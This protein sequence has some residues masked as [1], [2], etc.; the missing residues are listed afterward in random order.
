MRFQFSV[1]FGVLFVVMTHDALALWHGGGYPPPPAPPQHHPPSSPPPGPHQP[2]PGPPV[3]TPGG[4]SIPTPGP[5]GPH[6]PPVNTPKP[7]GG[8]SIPTKP[9]GGPS[10]PAP[11]GGTP[12]PSG[13]MP[14]PT[15]PSTPMMISG[16]NLESW[17]YWWAF[18]RDRFLR[19]RESVGR[20]DESP[21]TPASDDLGGGKVVNASMRPSRETLAAEVTP[22]LLNLLEKEQNADVKN[23]LMLALAEIGENPRAVLALLQKDISNPNTIVG[24]SATLAIGILGAGESIPV[25]KA[26]FE[27][28]PEGRELCNNKREVPWRLR[29]IAA[30][31]LGLAASV[32]KNPHH[33]TRIHETLIAPFVN[34]QKM[35]HR[36]ILVAAALA[37][38]MFPDES[39][40]AAVALEKYFNENRSRE[41]TICAHIPPA[42]ARILEKQ[43]AAER[44]RYTFTLLKL[45]NDGA[46]K[47]ERLIRPGAGIALG[48]LTNAADPFAAEVFQT[49][50]MAIDQDM[51]RNPETAYMSLISLGEIAGTAGPGN[52]MEKYLL[53]RALA[54]GGR[55]TTRAWAAIALG[56][57][58]F[59]QIDRRAVDGRDTRNRK[60]PVANDLLL[61]MNDMRDPEQLSAFAIALGLRRASAAAEK[62]M[63]GLDEIKVDDYRGYFA[64]AAGLMGAQSYTP[65]IREHVKNSPRRPAF[66]QQT[67]IGLALLGDKSVV[68]LLMDI[69][70]DHKNQGVAV[71]ASI[72]DA[73]GFVGDSR[74]VKPMLEVLI[75]LKKEH[76]STTRTFA[77]VSIGQIGDK[78][79]EP[80][81][82]KISKHL[83]YFAFV[84][85]LTD[86]VWEL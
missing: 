38:A 82:A 37:R 66:F 39:G 85:T 34:S 26:L 40:T 67:A 32:T 24:E 9:A 43:N 70:R 62:C 21:V 25:L 7:A 48:L 44:G 6:R 78:D 60:D 5:G 74:A 53:E 58:G 50:K 29:T 42:I 52:E 41:E 16:P 54:N 59:L 68:T 36:D 8:P 72:A 4:P 51:S 13:P 86:L 15:G 23:A 18:N 76:S 83:N 20:M 22:V 79:E 33:H 27:D 45:L 49:L 65:R 64:L 47:S 3:P 63:W 69:F 81:N 80:W 71:Q 28:A 46:R 12:V 1:L 75:D 11:Q 56:V 30:Y 57:E 31:G 10:T 55:V 77:A 14:A 17:Q 84:E 35:A 73:L 2:A 19:L 61:K